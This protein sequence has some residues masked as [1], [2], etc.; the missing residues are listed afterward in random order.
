MSMRFEMR[1]QQQQKYKQSRSKKIIAILSAEQA[2]TLT[3]YGLE[4]FPCIKAT[5]KSSWKM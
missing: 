4:T 1:P 2:I 3:S 5:M